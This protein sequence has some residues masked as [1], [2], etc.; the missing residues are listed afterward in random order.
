MNQLAQNKTI[1]L[2]DDELLNKIKQ[3][4][5]DLRH[6]N[7]LYSASAGEHYRPYVWL[8]DLYMQTL[9]LPRDK[10][11]QSWTSFLEYLVKTENETNK[12]KNIIEKGSKADPLHIRWSTLTNSE[13]EPEWGHLQFDAWGMSMIA[14]AK[15]AD[16]F[17]KNENYYNIIKSVIESV[18]SYKVW[19]MADTGAW[20]ENHEVRQ[21]SIACIA[22]GLYDL[23]PYF[24]DLKDKMDFAI[25]LCSEKVFKLWTNETDTRNCDLAQTHAILTCYPRNL[26]SRDQAIAIISK[27][28]KNLL[29]KNGVIRYKNDLY[30]NINCSTT[31][32]KYDGLYHK[33]LDGQYT[34][35]EAEW[36]FGLPK[37]IFCREI[38]GLSENQDLYDNL[39]RI[40]IE[41][42]GKIPELYYANTNIHNDNTP[43]GWACNL[44]YLALKREKVIF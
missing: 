23:R 30:Y 16:Y 19:E 8:R 3:A 44:T 14:I 10:Y 29:R 11:L 38:L 21:S 17:F 36:V 28:E 25:H 20:E 37:L 2:I 32:E 18:I 43:L 13:I 7:G 33:H 41:T 4:G 39:L 42:D 27:I 9:N 26:I 5:E 24:P 12:F 6:D 34:G 35:G 40:A 31:L 1:E 22:A 15:E